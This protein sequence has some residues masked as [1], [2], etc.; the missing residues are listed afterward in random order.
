MGYGL[1]KIFMFCS[2]IWNFDTGSLGYQMMTAF[3]SVIANILAEEW[4]QRLVLACSH[5]THPW[6]D[7]EDDGSLN[8]KTNLQYV[9]HSD[10]SPLK[11]AN[12]GDCAMIATVV[13]GPR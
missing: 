7:G 4:C 13:S 11:E 10:L 6:A 8:S 2:S 1:F 12:A 9:Y 5:V 3:E